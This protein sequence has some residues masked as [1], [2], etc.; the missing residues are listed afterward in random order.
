MVSQELPDYYTE[1]VILFKA[2]SSNIA[3]LLRQ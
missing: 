2:T 1:Q 3:K